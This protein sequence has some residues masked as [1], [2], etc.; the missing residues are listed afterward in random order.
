VCVVGCRGVGGVLVRVVVGGSPAASFS[1]ST[2]LPLLGGGVR[3]G[4]P[5]N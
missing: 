3:G 5:I 1:L 4:N 2:S